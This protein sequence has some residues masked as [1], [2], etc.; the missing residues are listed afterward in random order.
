MNPQ[1]R[2]IHGLDNI[3]AWPLAPGWWITLL[4]ILLIVALIA[5]LLRYLILYPPGSWH[6][7]A[8]RALSRLKRKVKHL[9]A[10][11]TA[12][13]LS[14]LLRRIV[15]ARL[16]R[17]GYA[18]LTNEDWLKCLKDIDRSEFDW[19]REG[20]LLLSLP[21]APEDDTV[22]SDQLEPLIRSTANLIA[23]RNSRKVWPFSRT[24][25]ALEHRDD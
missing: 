24:R 7:E 15:I 20:R 22:Q 1:L 8:Y 11:Q 21:Y 12:A 5:M 25:S 16:G 23:R 17:E 18:N 10:K 3:P 14:E 9:S 19:E 4:A 2:D 6:G 13:E